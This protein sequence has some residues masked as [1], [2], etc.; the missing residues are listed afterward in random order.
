VTLVLLVGEWPA[1]R[2]GCF[3]SGE[4]L[5]STRWIG[6]CM[7]PRVGLDTV[8]KNTTKLEVIYLRFKYVKIISYF[9]N[10]T[11][12]QLNITRFSHAMN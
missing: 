8:E 3:T 4:R 9:I 5:P 1:S 7:S 11:H 2:P 10:G 6:I 12:S